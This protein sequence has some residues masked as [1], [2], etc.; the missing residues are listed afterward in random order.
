MQLLASRNERLNI[1]S[2]CL[3]GLL[4][5]RHQINVLLQRLVLA[6]SMTSGL[7]D[8]VK[9]LSK[10]LSGESSSLSRVMPSF[11]ADR[12]DLLKVRL[13]LRYELVA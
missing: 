5:R 7:R 6:Q 4:G 11:M 13:D 1:I 8:I 2:D 10:R 3:M 12:V 9:T